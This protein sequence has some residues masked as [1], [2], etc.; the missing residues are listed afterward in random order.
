MATQVKPR[1]SAVW[2]TGLIWLLANLIGFGLV[3]ALFHNFPLALTFP[4]NL[5]RLGRFEL[6]PALLGVLLG[7]VPSLFIGL[8]QW[9]LLR[10]HWPVSRWWILTVSAGIGLQHFL[11]DGFPKARD[12][13]LAVLASSVVTGVLQW[14][15][16]RR[17]RPSSGWWLLAGVAGWSLGWL[18]GT[19][20]L[21]ALGMLH[22]PW[23]PELGLLQHGLPGM[24][25]GAGYGLL[26]GLTLLHLRAWPSDPA[27]R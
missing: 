12:L 11:A 21:D 19:L 25:A 3:G 24:L 22:V 6:E 1:P 27:R 18:L 20:L 26:T 14:R 23:T 4:P 13:S 7:A 10:R 5:A 16:L 8:A 17:Q 15:L 2:L 9:R